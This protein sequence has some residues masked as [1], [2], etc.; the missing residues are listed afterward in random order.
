[1]L[2]SGKKKTSD[3]VIMHKSSVFQHLFYN[4]YVYARNLKTAAREITGSIC[5]KNSFLI[6][7]EIRLL[8]LHT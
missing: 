7:A 1:M 2:N 5:W 4:N 3:Y 8:L 6:D